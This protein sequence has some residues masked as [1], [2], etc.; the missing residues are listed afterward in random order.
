MTDPS[1]R[2]RGHSVW[3]ERLI[4]GVAAATLALCWFLLFD[5]L[6]LGTP[7]LTAQRIGTAIARIVIEDP[8]SPTLVTSLVFFALL[9]F[10]GWI[11]IAS[12][13]LG[14]VHR[15][16]KRPS[17]LLPALLLSVILYLPLIGLSTMLVEIGWGSGTWARFLL[18]ALIGSVTVAAQAYRAHPGLVRYE[19]AHIQDDEES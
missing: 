12:L 1:G 4:A 18:A 19:L 15:A 5:G 14:V 3:R 7:W 10:G 13:V 6:T 2:L 16:E 11:G 9:H 17:I 8:V